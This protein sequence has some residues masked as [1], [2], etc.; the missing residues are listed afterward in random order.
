MRKVLFVCTGNTCRSPMAEAIYNHMAK[1]C[2]LEETHH[3]GSAGIYPVPGDPATAGAVQAVK[4]L[5]GEDLR[6]HSSRL[7]DYED[8]QGAWLVL[9]MT[10]RHVESIRD[11]FPG[12]E[13][14]V[15]TL[16]EYAGYDVRDRDISDPFGTSDEEYLSCAREIHAALMRAGDR[17]FVPETE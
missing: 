14:Y 9:A 3:A 11:A 17:L 6:G 5:F 13:D 15:F 8:M 7:L 4:T 1:E 16:K 12:M 2:G 10:M